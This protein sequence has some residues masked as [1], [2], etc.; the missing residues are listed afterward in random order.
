MSLTQVEA[1]QQSNANLFGLDCSSCE[2]YS[3]QL[4]NNSNL[5][6]GMKPQTYGENITRLKQ[7]VFCYIFSQINVVSD[8]RERMR[9]LDATVQF[10]YDVILLVIIYTHIYL[11]YILSQLFNFHVVNHELFRIA[12][13]LANHQLDNV[14]TTC[15]LKD[16]HSEQL[17]RVSSSSII[18]SELSLQIFF[19]WLAWCFGTRATSFQIGCTHFHN[20]IS[21][22]NFEQLAVKLCVC[23]YYI[24]F[25]PSN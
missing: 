4:I 21:R 9:K 10:K 16:Y 22:F 24:D 19:K 23:Q 12:A 11:N 18:A 13:N 15:M 5:F 7:L 17:V 3:Y 6:K 20:Q 25:T 14:N 2:I 1:G 8:I